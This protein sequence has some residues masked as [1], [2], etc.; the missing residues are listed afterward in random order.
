MRLVDD[1]KK[2]WKWF[3]MWAM[4]FSSV[5][6]GAWLYLPDDLKASVDHRIVSGMTLTLLVLGIAG[7]LVKQGE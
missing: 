3:S 7:R 6:Q 1:A 5:L 4:G 2:A